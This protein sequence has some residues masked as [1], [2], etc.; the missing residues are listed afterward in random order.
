MRFMLLISLCVVALLAGC[1]PTPSFTT[2]FS[3]LSAPLKVTF[4]DTTEV[5]D[6]LG[7]D[8]RAIAPITSWK[9]DFGDGNI[10]TDQNPTHVYYDHGAFDVSLTATNIGGSKTFLS[11]AAVTTASAVSFS[12][13]PAAG[14]APLT[15]K[16]TDTSKVPNLGSDPVQYWNWDFGDGTTTSVKDPSNVYRQPGVYTVTLAVSTT[17]RLYT[18]T[19]KQTVT[20]RDP[21]TGTT[22]PPVVPTVTFTANQT[23]GIAPLTV[24]FTDTTTIPDPTNNPITKWAW[25]F[26]DGGGS[27]EKNPQHTYQSAS[28]TSF[29]VKLTITMKSG[30][31]YSG[32]SQSLIKIDPGA[33]V[34]QFKAEGPVKGLLP[35]EVQFSDLSSPGAERITAWQWDFGDGSGSTAQ[36]P[37]HTYTEVGTYDVSLTVTTAVGSAIKTKTG[38]ITITRGPSASF[39]MSSSSGPKPLTIQFTDTSTPGADPGNPAVAIQTRQW[40]FGDTYTDSRTSP[41]HTYTEA[42]AY[43]VSLTVTSATGSDTESQQ[44]VSGVLPTADFTADHFTGSAP[45]SVQFTDLT[46]K[47][48]DDIATWDW[49]FGDTQHATTQ[50]PTHTFTVPGTYTVTL[51]VETAVGAPSRKTKTR[52][53]AVY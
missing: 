48:D 1:T 24:N 12:A 22:N 8:I 34:A 17:S 51:T 14:N 15:V 40:N 49:N 18:G 7:L 9:W 42:G 41:S 45:L 16:F 36:Y 43:T 13:S 47:G 27:T 11:K 2:E 44:V 32:T 20:V 6:G 4:K 23:A 38:Y 53:V 19:A 21:S 52:T 28:D 5:V 31:A 37:S 35:F 50:S 25:D 33:P 30:T 46:Q 39:A 29:T 10:S 26:G 3:G